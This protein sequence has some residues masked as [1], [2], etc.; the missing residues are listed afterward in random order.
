MDYFNIEFKVL[1]WDEDDFKKLLSA[2]DT[3]AELT[4]STEPFAVYK[5]DLPLILL[6]KYRVLEGDNIIF[7]YAGQDKYQLQ[8]KIP[9][10]TDLENVKDIHQ[11]IDH[12]HLKYCLEWEERILESAI[13]GRRPPQLT[14]EDISR[15]SVDILILAKKLGLVPATE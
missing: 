7:S 14:I 9:Q 12:S 8:F 13:S 4:L 3:S 5:G 11:M 6:W 2:R 10:K 15:T 1:H